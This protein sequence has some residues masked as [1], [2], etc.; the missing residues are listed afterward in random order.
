MCFHECPMDSIRRNEHEK[1]HDDS[2][3]QEERKENELQEK[4]STNAIKI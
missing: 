4:I 1:W 3:K 2:E